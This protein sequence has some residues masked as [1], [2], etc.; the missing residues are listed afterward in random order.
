[1]NVARSTSSLGKVSILHSIQDLAMARTSDHVS[2]ASSVMNSSIEGASWSDG[3]LDVLNLKN[4]S[5]G[6]GGEDVDLSMP[7][8]FGAFIHHLSPAILCLLLVSQ[9]LPHLP[10]HIGVLVGITSIVPELAN[11]P[12]WKMNP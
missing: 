1:M 7:H 3:C 8:G 2:L 12:I 6:L 11:I 4:S 5:K 10:K 9:L